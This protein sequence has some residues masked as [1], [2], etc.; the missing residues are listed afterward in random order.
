MQ[1]LMAALM[2]GAQGGNAP[3]REQSGALIMNAL[4]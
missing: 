2:T 1:A 4:Q 3:Q